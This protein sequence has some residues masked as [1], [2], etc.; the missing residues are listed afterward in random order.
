MPHPT[1]A[2][3]FS[4]PPTATLST[5]VASWSG[6]IGALPTAPRLKLLHLVRHAQGW[7]NVD[8]EGVSRVPSGLDARLT[9][10]GERQCAALSAV[11]AELQPEVIVSSPLMR[12][13]QTAALSF[14]GQLRAGVPLVAL[15][16][17]RETVNYLCDSRRPLSVNVAELAAS[18]VAVDTAGCPHEHDELWASY[19]RRHG[20]QEAFAA[21]RESADLPGLA[22]RAR[23]AFAWLG[24][25]PERE[26]VLVSHSAFFMNTLNMAR[27][28]RA[29]GVAPL[30]DFG[31]DAELERWLC[32]GF[33]NCEMR[34]VWCE[35]LE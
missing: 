26:L 18:G 5:G 13:L 32:A 35:F 8:P 27:V 25:R 11:A 2:V 1:P 23:S 17:C 21:H 19:E 33:E 9:P 34:S 14:G 6:A 15:E 16:D 3:R 31:G 22:V 20:P 10:E 4:L 12:T 24:A 28:G 7:H 30:V 29:A